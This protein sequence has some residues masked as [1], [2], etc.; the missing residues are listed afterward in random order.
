[1]D[2]MMITACGL[3]AGVTACG[4]AAFEWLEARIEQ[5]RRIERLQRPRA[6]D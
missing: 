2:W 4:V 1:M 5:R 6:R 3:M